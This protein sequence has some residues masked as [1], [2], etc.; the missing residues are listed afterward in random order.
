MKYLL[1]I[2]LLL[3]TGCASQSFKN[4]ITDGLLRQLQEKIIR[5]MLRDVCQLKTSASVV[6]M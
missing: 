5:E 4:S 6:S 3:L 1:I 2:A